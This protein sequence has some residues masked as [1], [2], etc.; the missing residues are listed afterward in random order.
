MV[1]A[2]AGTQKSEA[3][4]KAGAMAQGHQPAG[5]SR[6]RFIVRKVGRDAER[7]QPTPCPYTTLTIPLFP[8]YDPPLP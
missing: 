4:A 7:S 2:F 8:P 3:P 5:F 1:P 6:R